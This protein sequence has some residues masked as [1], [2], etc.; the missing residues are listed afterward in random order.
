MENQAGFP[1][2]KSKNSQVAKY[3][4]KDI[5]QKL[6]TI[7]TAKGFTLQKAISCACELSDQIFGIYAGDHESYRVF[8]ELFEPIICD[9]HNVTTSRSHKSDFEHKKIEG[10]VNVRA[11]V[12]STRI[13][14]GRNLEGFALSPAIS[15]EERLKF[16]RLMKEVFNEL[17]GE[18]KGTYYSLKDLDE[19]TK[20][21]LIDE[22][23]LFISGDKNLIA[24]GME[25]DWPEGRGIFISDDRKFSL[26]VNEEDQLRIVSME[27][28]S[29]VIGTFARLATGIQTISK[30]IHNKTG[31]SFQFDDK[32]GFIH[33]CPTNLGTGM[34]ASV[35]IHLPGWANKSVDDLKEKAKKIGLQ[36]TISL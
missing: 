30:L 12:A 33:S 29:D 31:K 22:H 9:Y 20:Q 5:W 23:L 1:T 13:R 3:L 15:K 10:N 34:R 36:V 7:V 28:G 17:T 4:T 21:L 24:A 27:K 2:L 35:H 18:L 14:V 8:S 25:R 11:P 19:P 32:N 16:E 26:W 6:C